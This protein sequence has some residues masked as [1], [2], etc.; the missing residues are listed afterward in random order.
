[1]IKSVLE[2]I[3]R[4]LKHF[5]MLSLINLFHKS[6]GNNTSK[7]NALIN[8]NK[9]EFCENPDQMKSLETPNLMVARAENEKEEALRDN[10]K[11]DQPH[12]IIK[13]IKINH[14]IE[15]RERDLRFKQGY[16]VTDQQKKDIKEDVM[17]NQKN[18]DELEEVKRNIAI[19]HVIEEQERSLRRRQGYILSDQQKKEIK[20]KVFEEYKDTISD[21]DVHKK[22][23]NSIPSQPSAQNKKTAPQSRHVPQKVKKIVMTRDGR[24]CV[25]CGAREYLEYDHKIPFS[26]GG[27][28]QKDNIQILCRKCNLKKGPNI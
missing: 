25:K 15:R 4:I 5:H 16:K 21:L 20:E 11:N 24:R 28:N 26:K 27:S 22:R 13:N 9:T 12:E 10:N 8:Q 23:L 18:I 6:N 17:R 19:F 1:M 3:S 7:N 14:E 2:K